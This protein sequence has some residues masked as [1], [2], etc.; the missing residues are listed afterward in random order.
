MK[1]TQIASILKK[2]SEL[3]AAIGD[4]ETAL[5]RQMS[6]RIVE[7][8]VAKNQFRSLLLDLMYQVHAAAT[9]AA[10]APAAAKTSRGKRG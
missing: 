5:P 3:D 1:E 6:Q 8:G 4:V 10:I 9:K 7:L 2:W